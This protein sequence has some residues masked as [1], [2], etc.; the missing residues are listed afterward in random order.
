MYTIS[1]E[2][3]DDRAAGTRQIWRRGKVQPPS[4][5]AAAG[6]TAGRRPDLSD[7]WLGVYGAECAQQLDECLELGFA[8]RLREVLLEFRMQRHKFCRQGVARLRQIKN[9]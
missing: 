8:E 6:R 7:F 4:A 2:H 5:M 3:D 1:R 9:M